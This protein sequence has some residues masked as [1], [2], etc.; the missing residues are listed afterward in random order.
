[1]VSNLLLIAKIYGIHYRSRNIL[2]N[3]DI[4]QCKQIRPSDLWR[5][6][7]CR[8]SAGRKVPRSDWCLRH[9]SSAAGPLFPSHLSQVFP[10]RSYA[11]CGWSLA[12]HS[13]LWGCSLVSLPSA[14]STVAWDHHSSLLQPSTSLFRLWPRNPVVASLLISSSKYSVSCSLISWSNSHNSVKDLRY[15]PET[16]YPV[17]SAQSNPH[18]SKYLIN[19]AKYA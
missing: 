18:N 17:R 1:M 13:G 16:S 14:C 2:C 4:L 3:K 10:V 15:L 5:P 7:N 9:I 12:M 6:E 11:S 8:M 19:F